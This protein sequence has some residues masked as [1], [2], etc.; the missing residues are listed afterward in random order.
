MVITKQ[1]WINFYK[2]I[3]ILSMLYSIQACHL[4]HSGTLALSKFNLVSCLLQLESN[5]NEKYEKN[6]VN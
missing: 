4:Y 2:N 6:F 3:N 5:E 1:L